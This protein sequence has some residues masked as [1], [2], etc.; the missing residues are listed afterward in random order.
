MCVGACA[1]PTPHEQRF[2]GA[3]DGCGARAATLTRMG[4]S[5]TFTPSD[6]VLVLP[7]TVAADGAVA[8][9]LNTQLPGKPPFLLTLHGR[10]DAERA[11]LTYATPR[12]TAHGTLKRVHPA[13]F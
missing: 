12:C 7:G 1:S 3:L 4:E 13:A 9:A 10:M 5:I 2:T 8:A 11:E 6:G